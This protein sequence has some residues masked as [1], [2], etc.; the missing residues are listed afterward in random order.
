MDL[1]MC[2]TKKQAQKKVEIGI[3]TFYAA[4]VAILKQHITK[5]KVG[6]NNSC[7]RIKVMSVD[8]FQGSESD[9][10][11]LSFVRS[12]KKSAV[13]FLK[14]FQRLNVALTRAKHNLVMFGDADT[15]ENSDCKDLQR[16]I[17]DMKNRSALIDKKCFV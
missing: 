15:L 17:L 4:Q 8:G 3:I 9:I 2:L 1:R 16:L 12:N 7:F 10:I 5:S 6:F 11:I 13:G 14:D